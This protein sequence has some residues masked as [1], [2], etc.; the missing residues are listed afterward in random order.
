MTP[1]YTLSSLTQPT[2]PAPGARRTGLIV[3]LVITA[4]VVLAGLAV[5]IAVLLH[6]AGT[7]TVNGT[8][9]IPAEAAG[10]VNG[11]PCS[12]HDAFA[13][14]DKGA[15]VQITDAGNA[16]IALTQLA[17]G[18]ITAAGCT[19]RWTASNVPTGKNF[20]GVAVGRRPGTKVPEVQMHSLVA[21][22]VG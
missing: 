19:F 13:D 6:S 3:T 20:Y 12:G 5:G 1:D 22:T 14:I 4:V 7:M 8:L 21:L 10:A 17:D 2:G 18:N 9:T 16:T 15:E 11:D